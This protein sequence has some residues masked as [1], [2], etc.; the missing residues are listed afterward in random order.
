M[1]WESCFLMSLLVTVNPSHEVFGPSDKGRQRNGERSIPHF[2]VGPMPLW[3]WS[4]HH[5]MRSST[6]CKCQGPPSRHH[7]KQQQKGPLG[8]LWGVGMWRSPRKARKAVHRCL[9]SKAGNTGVSK[10]Q[11]SRGNPTH[12][13]RGLHR[14]SPCPAESWGPGAGTLGSLPAAQR[15]ALHP[16]EGERSQ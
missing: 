12:T 15:T 13:W 11:A 8:Q 5:E 7:Q 6:W 3:A 4:G 1:V 9:I 2:W 14:G 16:Q 10:H